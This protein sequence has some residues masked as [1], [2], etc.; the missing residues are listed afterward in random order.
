MGPGVRHL[1]APRGNLASRA[2][3][4]AA[5]RH[6][7]WSDPLLAPETPGDSSDPGSVDQVIDHLGLTDPGPGDL[8]LLYEALLHPAQRAAGAHYTPAD[9]ARRL[10]TAALG[11]HRPGDGTSPV[12]V[13][14]PTCG[15]GAFL[16]AAADALHDLGH[17][18]SVIV[19]E[20]LWGTD[21]DSGA[22]AVADAALR[23]WAEVR[24]AD[25]GSGAHLNVADV[26]LS[27]CPVPE[28]CLAVVGNPPFQGQMRGETVRDRERN[29]RLRERWGE[30]IGPYTD[31]A[32]LALVVGVSALRPTGRLAMVLPTSVLGARDAAGVRDAVSAVAALTGLWVAAEPVFSA[33]VD[34]C[35][36]VLT[37]GG[38]APVQRWRGRSFHRLADAEAPVDGRSWAPLAAAA[39]GVPEPVVSTSGTLADVAEVSAGF[40]DEYYGLI[41]HVHEGPAGLD[42]G[43]LLGHGAGGEQRHLGPLITS[44]LIEPGRVGWGER[45]VRFAKADYRRPVV[46]L[47]S[48][49]AAGGRAAARVDALTV[50]KLLVATQTKVG[51][52]AVDER[53]TW[54]ASTPIITAVAPFEWLWKL[55]AVVCSPVGS[56][57]AAAATAGTGRATGSIKHS[58]ASV[59]ELPLPVDDG[60]WVVG[61]E[62]LR[63][64]NREEFVAA[65]AAAYRL[66]D[67]SGVLRTWWTER[68]P[69]DR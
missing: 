24:G 39:L 54:V 68:A 17:G 57:L 48:L 45:P 8:G 19:S 22:V 63:L 18:P 36:L 33:E 38:D 11:E 41:G 23:W 50:P 65:M 25:A 26:F 32:A 16:L 46:D 21:V 28:G 14:D 44:G 47:S 5:R 31:T 37:V 40:R 35:A 59:R 52:A 4:E 13:W 2:V 3:I 66:V 56:A 7:W 58:V 42:I 43:Q 51:E 30:V 27:G 69:W 10:V 62:A 60:A 9:V 12:T 64:G 67:G 1:T 61:A 20:M 55:A 6:G 53:G 15:G 34:V 29:R 49:R